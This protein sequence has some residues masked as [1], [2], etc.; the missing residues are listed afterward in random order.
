MP[1]IVLQLLP[2]VFSIKA[3]KPVIRT[4]VWEVCFRRDK[5]LIREFR[6]WVREQYI[7]PELGKKTVFPLLSS[8]LF[9]SFPAKK[10]RTDGTTTLVFSNSL[11]LTCWWNGAFTLCCPCRCVAVHFFI[12]ACCPAVSV[13]WSTACGMY[14]TAWVLHFYILSFPSWSQS[15]W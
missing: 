4:G 3:Q 11:D 14:C 13:I 15:R 6:L 7:T 9:S 1:L 2:S 12:A 10:F 8:H 5:S